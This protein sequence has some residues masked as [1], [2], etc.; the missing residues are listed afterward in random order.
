MKK[1]LLLIVPFLIT[2]Y[3]AR[4][5]VVVYNDTDYPIKFEMSWMGKAMYWCANL[6]DSKC[7]ADSAKW[8]EPIGPHRRR[9]R[10][11][12]LWNIK[13]RYIISADM[14]GKGDYKVVINRG[15]LNDTFNRDILVRYNKDEKDPQKRWTL[16]SAGWGDV[17]PY[18]RQAFMQEGTQ[19][20]YYKEKPITPL[21]D[22]AKKAFKID[23]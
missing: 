7:W 22:Y 19:E 3:E 18:I 17:G 21:T 6:F 11:G 10:G 16:V 5:D 4:A 1:V 13:N 14:T 9:G 8:A 2:Y 12:E 15:G 20:E 23:K